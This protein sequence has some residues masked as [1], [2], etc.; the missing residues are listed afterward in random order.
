VAR[1]STAMSQG[2]ICAAG[3][4]AQRAAGVE[5]SHERFF[6]D[7]MA[8]TR[9]QTD[10]VLA[11]T[12]AENAGPALDWLICR[13]N[14]ISASAPPTATAWRACMAGLGMAERT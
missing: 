8:K 13:S 7:I 11:R 9:G 10:P 3:T 12:I 6:A 1:G 14:S 2:L 5:D 4:A